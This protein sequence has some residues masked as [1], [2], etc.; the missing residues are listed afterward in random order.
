MRITSYQKIRPKPK[1]VLK[2]RFK[3]LKICN[4]NFFFLILFN[5]LNICDIFNIIQFHLSRYQYAIPL[6]IGDKRSTT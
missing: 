1:I 6:R 5:L 3:F 4:I 2:S